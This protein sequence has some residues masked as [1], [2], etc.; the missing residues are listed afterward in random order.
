MPESNSNIQT[1]YDTQRFYFE[2][3]PICYVLAFCVIYQKNLSESIKSSDLIVFIVFSVVWCL[4]IRWYEKVS[5]VEISNSSI[6][7]PNG[8]LRR[9]TMKFS[10]IKAVARLV[11]KTGGLYISYSDETGIIVN[12]Y[13]PQIDEIE[14]IIKMKRPD[15]EILTNTNPLSYF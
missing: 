9:T 14:T 4:L 10:D 8:N 7:G 12:R 6:S 2:L 1:F 3:G 15:I 11:G 5:S 13:H